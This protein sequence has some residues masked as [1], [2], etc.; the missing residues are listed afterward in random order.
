MIKVVGNRAIFEIIAIFIT[1]LLIGILIAIA[2]IRT[3]SVSILYNTLQDPRFADLSYALDATL[4]F[5]ITLLLLRR[6]KHHSN[7]ILFEA[8]EGIVI[9]F[10]SFFM[11]LLLFAILI[12]QSVTSGY[13]YLY[14]ATLAIMLVALKD[15]FHRLSDFATVVSAIGVGLILGFNFAFEYAI[16]I[17]AAVAVYDYIGVFKTNEMVTLAKAFSSGNVSFLISVSDLEAVPEWGL[18]HKEIEDYMNYLSSIHELNDPPFKKIL[19]HGRLPVIC[20]L[21]L[22][23]GD[24]SLPLMVAVSAFTSFSHMLGAVV[25]MGSVAGIFL[26]MMLLK[27]Y[28]HPIPAIPPLFASVGIFTGIAF[29]FIHAT[30]T[31]QLGILIVAA[32]ALMMLIDIM[33]IAK[34]MHRERL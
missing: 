8:L 5:I 27:A 23:E 19:Q 21:A 26:T 16:L 20:Q 12:P 32:S 4:V 18:S 28:K 10:T 2:A 13:V 24:L 22:G 11:L 31:Y 25:I 17:F 1:V 3:S 6:H 7:T 34:R 14:A 30:N 29:L 15:K 33:T 9:S